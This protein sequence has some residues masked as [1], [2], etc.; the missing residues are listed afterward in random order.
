MTAVLT[1]SC[2]FPSYGTK[3]DVDA[4]RESKSN[5]ENEK[6][7][8]EKTIEKLEVLKSD[9]ASYVNQLDAELNSLNKQ[10]TALNSR[11]AAKEAEIEEAEAELAASKEDE[12]RQ[13]ES[14]KLRIQYMYE[15]G[16]TSYLDLLFKSAD[17]TQLFNRAEY[18]SQI[19]AYDRKML[20]QYEAASEEVAAREADLKA[21]HEE[22]VAL[23]TNTEEKQKDAER[24]MNEKTAE[25]KSY[26]SK[27]AASE[28]SLSDL[29]K[30]IAAQED[31]IKKAALEAGRSIIP[32]VLGILT[33]YGHVRPAAGSPPR[34][35]T[36]NLRRKAR[37]P[38]IRASISAHPR[39]A[40]FWRRLQVP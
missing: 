17:L 19:A 4:A 13:Y 14:M 27:I 30:D 12:R 37:R 39:A 20:D 23:K 3:T 28:G 21:E 22:L 15:K 18:I 38:A 36:G 7:E 8:I 31:K 34:L 29:E 26:N 10:V 24:L 25:L 16:E 1:V 33:S 11:V 2:I 5:L 9:T 35:E 40:A 6:K 32:L